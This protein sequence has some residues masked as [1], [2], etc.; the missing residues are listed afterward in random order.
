MRKSIKTVL[1]ATTLVAGIGGAVAYAMPPGG[2]AC[3]RG[4][5]AEF[6]RHGMDSE[7]R[8]DRMSETLGLSAEQRSKVREIVDKARPAARELR[9]KLSD[10]RK[11]LWAL[12]Q[13]DKPNEGE[14]RKLADSQGKLVAD[15]IVQRTRMQSQIRAVLTPEQR[16]ALKQRFGRRGPVSLVEPGD[17]PASLSG[18]DALEGN[19]PMLNRT[20]M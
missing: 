3:A 10:N 5:G 12:M 18:D 14:V 15:M 1:F 11:Q 7:R 17:Q 6:G 20:A 16:D 2:E 8:I 13:Q 19:G 9:D 4:H